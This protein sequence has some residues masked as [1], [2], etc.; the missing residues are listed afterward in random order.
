[1]CTR[2]GVVGAKVARLRGLNTKAEA[3]PSL[4]FAVTE[5]ASYL[6]HPMAADRRAVVAEPTAREA[7]V[8][9]AS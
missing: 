8:A 5:I 4:A 3:C 7:E 6:L 2:G 9:D 1:M